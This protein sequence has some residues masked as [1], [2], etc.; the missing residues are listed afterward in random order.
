MDIAGWLKDEQNDVAADSQIAL[1]ATIAVF[2]LVRRVA[3]LEAAL[4]PL[5]LAAIKEFGDGANGPDDA[6]VDPDAPAGQ[7]ITFGML[8]K[9]WAAIERDPI[10]SK[11]DIPVLTGSGYRQITLDVHEHGFFD[12]ET[13]RESPRGKEI[14]HQAIA[15]AARQP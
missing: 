6:S 5:A 7:G 1:E 11:F 13:M 15:A 14:I 8:R 4:R 2:A 10:D 12:S 9:A 3:E